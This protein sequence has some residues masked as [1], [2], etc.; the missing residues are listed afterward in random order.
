MNIQ[1]LVVIIVCAL[2]FAAESTAAGLGRAVI[3]GSGKSIGRSLRRPL[4][5]PRLFDLKRDRKTPV[6]VLKQDRMVDRYTRSAR[7]SAEA[8]RG[9]PPY[10][11]M[12]STS[13]RKPLTA[14][15]AK[16]RLGLSTTP[17]VVERI[18]LKKGTRLHFNKVVGGKPGYGEITVPSRLPKSSI[19]R[20]IKLRR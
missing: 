11:H 9:I 19:S 17:D 8:K 16:R 1:K 2:G 5:R 12:T 7:A 15:I 18:Q 3:R 14:S 13:S 4:S 20:V 6:S 10:T